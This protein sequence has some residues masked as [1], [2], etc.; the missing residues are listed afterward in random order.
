MST[1]TKYFKAWL[2][3]EGI[4]KETGLKQVLVWPKLELWVAKLQQGYSTRELSHF[5][6]KKSAF[7]KYSHSIHWPEFVTS[8]SLHLMT[9]YLG[10]FPVGEPLLRY[11]SSM[12][13]D[14][15]NMAIHAGSKADSA[16]ET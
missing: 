15:I 6:A 13:C 11:Y 4:L 5:M 2:V 10:A 12:S 1:R 9:S 3:R 16:W 8:N 14:K 7:Q